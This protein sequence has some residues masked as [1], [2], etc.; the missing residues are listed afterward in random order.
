MKT[1]ALV[2]LLTPLTGALSADV[3]Q[4]IAHRGASLERP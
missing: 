2:V 4:I 3:T 1:A